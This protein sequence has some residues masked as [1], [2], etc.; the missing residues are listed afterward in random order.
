MTDSAVVHITTRTGKVR[1]E[2]TDTP[3]LSVDGGMIERHDDGTLHIT[4]ASWSGSIDVRCAPGTDV[5][6][7]TVSGSVDLVGR[8]GAVRVATVSGRI[9]VEEASRIDLRTKS[10]KVDIGT[11]TGS[12]PGDDE[13]L[14]RARAPRGSGHDRRRLGRGVARAGPRR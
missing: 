6:V 4:R 10:G 3:E 11:C 7:G 5:T 1:V 2:A 8:L 12:V 9:R 14:G 13:E